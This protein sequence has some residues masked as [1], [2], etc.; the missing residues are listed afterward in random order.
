VPTR[1][2]AGKS[3]QASRSVRCARKS[4][5][6]GGRRPGGATRKPL[7]HAVITAGSK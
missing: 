4:S 7:P 6:I 3:P 5:T 2:S 1:K